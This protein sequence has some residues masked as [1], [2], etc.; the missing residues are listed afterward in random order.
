M[1][2][3]KNITYG[4]KVKIEKNAKLGRVP[5]WKRTLIFEA[6]SKL[7]NFWLTTGCARNRG[8]CE[9]KNARRETQSHTGKVAYDAMHTLPSH[10]LVL[11]P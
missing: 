3:V 7:V 6:V 1:D 4:F 11:V 9:V 2:K 8:P 10:V 5:R